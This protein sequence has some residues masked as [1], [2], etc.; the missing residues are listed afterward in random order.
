[1]NDFKPLAVA[2][3]TQAVR[4][5]DNLMRKKYTR[6]TSLRYSLKEIKDFLESDWGQ[7]VCETCGFTADI[8]QEELNKRLNDYLRRYDYV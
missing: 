5:W 7:F 2:I 4:D 1:M 6:E 8:V 3:L